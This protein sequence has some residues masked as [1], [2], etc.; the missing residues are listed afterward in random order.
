MYIFVNTD[1]KMSFGQ[2]VAQVAHIVQVITEEIVRES[3]EIVPVPQY[4]LT[5]MK[6]SKV[7]TKVVLGATNKQILELMKMDEARHF[8]DDIY[9]SNG[10]Y[11]D[12]VTQEVTVVGFFPSATNRDYFNKFRLLTP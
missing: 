2:T 3:Y 7:C 1:L 11:K 4:C 5:Y 12:T 9:Y 6:W 8:I 10:S